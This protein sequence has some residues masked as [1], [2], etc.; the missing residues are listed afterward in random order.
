M[1]C[2]ALHQAHPVSMPEMKSA[3]L[4]SSG[5]ALASAP[6]QL[7]L[8]SSRA[9]RWPDFISKVWLSSGFNFKAVDIRMQLYSYPCSFTC[10]WHHKAAVWM[11]IPILACSDFNADWA[12]VHKAIVNTVQHQCFTWTCLR[13]MPVH[14]HIMNV[15]CCTCTS[16]HTCETALQAGIHDSCTTDMNGINMMYE[17]KRHVMR[18][19]L[20]IYK[21]NLGCLWVQR[22]HYD[23]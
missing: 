8:S 1:L 19:L 7:P 17:I 4:L 16:Y 14:D 9:Q 11:F 12:W 22:L 21:H 18:T 20:W 6:L 23:T 15:R 10:V 13:E 2:M 5:S 3:L